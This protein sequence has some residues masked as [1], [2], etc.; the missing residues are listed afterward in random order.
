MSSSLAQWSALV[1]FLLPLLVA[2]VQRQHW[3]NNV[4]TIVGV[5]ACAIA[6]ILTTWI[7]GNLNLHNFGQSVIVIFM[8][9]KTSYLAV[10]KPT[11]TTQTIEQS[12]PGNSNP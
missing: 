12:S 7:E 2:F 6:A 9:T 3:S 4:R 5:A 11:G 8:M 1:G 10:W